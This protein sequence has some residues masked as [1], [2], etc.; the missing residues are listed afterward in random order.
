MNAYSISSDQK[1]CLRI[2]QATDMHLFTQ[3]NG[4]LLGVD[5][6]NSFKAVLREL[7]HDTF[8]A[9]ILTGDLAQEPTDQSYE[10]IQTSLKEASYPIFG[11]PGNHDDLDKLN[12]LFNT[13]PFHSEKAIVSE[14]WLVLM[15]NSQV[16]GKIYGYLAD[17]EFDWMSSQLSQYPNH[18]ALIFLHHHPVGIGSDWIKQHDLKNA[19]HF[20]R[21][22]KTHPQ[23]KVVSFG[24]VHQ[25]FATW[26]EGV[27]FCAT[28]STSVQF[29]SRS[30][31]FA[32]SKEAPGYRWFHL[33][34][35]GEFQTANTFCPQFQSTANLRSQGY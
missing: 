4:L 6:L 3:P 16:P 32:I 28:V 19:L 11:I 15:L 22:I 20:K 31:T 8:D 26:E 2:I 13:P 34:A 1:G 30:H 33:H 10:H 24:H 14:H 27:L 7:Q 21:F 12:A 17:Q 18:H 5:T 29:K 25:N 35:N 9:L 23:I